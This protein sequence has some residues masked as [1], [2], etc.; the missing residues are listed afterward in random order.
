M[1]VPSTRQP[2]RQVSPL[3]HEHEQALYQ[4]IV[5]RIVAVADPDKVILFGSRARGD[6][7]PDSDLDILVIKESSEPRHTRA[8][9]LFGA[10]ADLPLEVDILVCTPQ[11]IQEWSGVRQAFITT[12][13]REGKVVYE[14][15]A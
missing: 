12:A 4:E 11:E 15:T 9:P 14:R 5:R 3:A 7:R 13:T 10:L 2:G 6:H 8:R 1:S